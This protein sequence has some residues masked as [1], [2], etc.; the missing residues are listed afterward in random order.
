MRARLLIV[1]LL[2]AA[3]LV[4]LPA[5]AEADERP[6]GS[7]GAYVDP[8]GDPTA[9]ADDGDS[10]GGGG[11]SSE[12]DEQ[13]EWHIVVD[14][15]FEFAMYDVDFTRLHSESGRWL[16]YRCPD[17]GAV[18]V[19]GFFVIPE[20][21][22]VDPYQLAVDAVASVGIESPPI[23]TSPSENGRLYVQ[24][25]TWLWLE[26]SWWQPYEA[27]ARAGRVWSTVRANPVATTWSMGD[28]H[29]VSCRGPGVQWRA[30]LPED[31]SNCAH[32]YR[33][34]SAGSPGGT[35]DLEATVTL[36]VSWFSNAPD[37]GGGLPAISRTSSRDVEVG[38]IQAIGTRGGR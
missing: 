26:Q 21:G 36:E 12:D 18:E 17:Q 7:G 19:D 33:K 23:R 11:G 30:A 27:T 32:T 13:C 5:P 6:G 20:G 24:V 38:E 14:D 28:G 22:L 37:S 15:D 29:N 34:S 3:A 31:A 25:P 35:F 9:V 1:A 2:G 8:D 4:A 10:S 16:E